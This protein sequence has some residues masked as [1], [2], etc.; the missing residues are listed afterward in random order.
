[1]QCNAMLGDLVQ[2][3]P[4]LTL[5]GGG[6]GGGATSAAEQRLRAL[7][8]RSG[9]DGKKSF[10]ELSY[11]TSY[12]AIMQRPGLMPCR[13]GPPRGEQTPR[14]ASAARITSVA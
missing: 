8:G 3:P 9:R 2:A 14:V 4:P 1:M 6:D 5:G 7:R 11:G 12:H 10:A 13:H